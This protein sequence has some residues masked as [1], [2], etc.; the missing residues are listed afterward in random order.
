[1][2]ESEHRVNDL[3]NLLNRNLIHDH[4]TKISNRKHFVINIYER[5]TMNAAKMLLASAVLTFEARQ[6]ECL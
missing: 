5:F 2:T 6:L 1:M 4:K 3:T